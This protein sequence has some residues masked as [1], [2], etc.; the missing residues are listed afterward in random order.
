MITSLQSCLLYLFLKCIHQFNHVILELRAN[1][2]WSLGDISDWIGSLKWPW[3]FHHG[4]TLEF[5]SKPQEIFPLGLTCYS[6]TANVSDLGIGCPNIISLQTH[7]KG[8]LWLVQN[9]HLPCSCPW[10]LQ[11]CTWLLLH[12]ALSDTTKDLYSKFARA[13]NFLTSNSTPFFSSFFPV[14]WLE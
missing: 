5:V 13:T 7:I 3:S 14:P 6:C 12:S 9:D 11:C 2:C 10:I 4:I 8:V 1:S